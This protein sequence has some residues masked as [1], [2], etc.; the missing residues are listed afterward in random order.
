MTPGDLFLPELLLQTFPDQETLCQ[1]IFLV[2]FLGFT[3]FSSQTETF[4]T[5]KDSWCL[6]QGKMS[7][8][9]DP[10]Q[11]QSSSCSADQ[12]LLFA[13]MFQATAGIEMKA[14][15]WQSAT[16]V[17]LSVPCKFSYN[18][19]SG[20]EPDASWTCG[21]WIWPV[22]YPSGPLFP[23]QIEFNMT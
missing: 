18:P 16:H 10:S 2:L 20:S 1:D 3:S 5:S 17:V 23:P 7:K 6:L 12:F 19:T 14:G 8:Q 9:H 11:P 21:G 13:I 15:V 4:K 22:A